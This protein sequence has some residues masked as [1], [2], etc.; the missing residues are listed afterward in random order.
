[1]NLKCDVMILMPGNNPEAIGDLN[2]CGGYWNWDFLA[3]TC[4]KIN[5]TG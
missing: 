5:G 1:M 3:Q 2:S 4:W